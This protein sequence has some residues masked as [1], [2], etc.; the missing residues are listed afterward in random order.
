MPR[1]TTAARHRLPGSTFAL[2]GRR[3]PINDAAHGRNALARV[4]QYGSPA[5]Q[6]RVRSAVHAKFPAIGAK[7]KKIGL[8]DHL[9]SMRQR[10]A[11]A[12]R[13]AA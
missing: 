3:Y 4:S 13:G 6:A 8:R 7:K 10:G 9:T 12:R 2:P 5:E 1:L 11:F